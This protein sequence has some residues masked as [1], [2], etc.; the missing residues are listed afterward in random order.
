MAAPVLTCNETWALPKRRTKPKN[1]VRSEIFKETNR[2]HIE[3]PNQK[4]TDEGRIKYFLKSIKRIIMEIT[5]WKSEPRSI[6]N[7]CCKCKIS[8]VW[9][10]RCGRAPKKMTILKTEQY[11]RL[12]LE[13]KKQNTIVETSSC[14][15]LTFW[16]ISAVGSLL[17][18]VISSFYW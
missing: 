5:Y 13:M 8:T 1:T 6:G 4:W 3:K 2:M 14:F 12:I 18:L 15:L 10:K 7:T 11:W 16:K 17:H 9:K